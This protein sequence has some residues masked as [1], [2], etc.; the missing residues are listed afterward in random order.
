MTER[1][2]L[3][4][5]VKDGDE[6]SDVVDSSLR[7]MAEIRELSPASVDF[8]PGEGDRTDPDRP[9][10]GA[11]LATGILVKLGDVALKKLVDKLVDWAG[12][13][14][15]RIKLEIDGD[16]IELDSASKAERAQLLAIFLDKHGRP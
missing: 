11:A 16:V 6:R 9:G 14:K 10:K 13:S 2:A 7:L 1:V 12:R 15:R 5:L 3:S 8:V 4:V